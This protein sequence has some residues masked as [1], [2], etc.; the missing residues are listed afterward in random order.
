MKQS[1]FFNKVLGCQH[2]FFAS[3]CAVLIL[4]GCTRKCRSGTVLEK[5]VCRSSSAALAESDTQGEA[6][7][8]GASRATGLSDG[9]ADESGETERRLSN[10]QAAAGGASE[11]NE[12]SFATA[13]VGGANQ[14]PNTAGTFAGAASSGNGGNDAAR[15]ECSAGEKACVGQSLRHCGADGLWMMEMPCPFVCADGACVGECEPGSRQCSESTVQECDELGNWM[16]S[17]VCP[18]VCLDGACA[19]SCSPGS[20][21]CSGS[22]P[23]TC[24]ASGSWDNGTGCEFLCTNGECT[25]ECRPNDARCEGNRVQTC[26]AQGEWQAGSSCPFVCIDGSCTGQCRPDDV[27]C[28]GSQAERCSSEGRWEVDQ[29]CPYLCSDGRCTGSCKPGDTRCG[30]SSRLQVC[31]ANGSWNT[32]MVST[33]CGAECMPGQPPICDDHVPITCDSQGRLVRGRIQENTCGAQCT[34]GKSYDC[35][36]TRKP[37]CNDQ[38]EFEYTVTRDQCGAEC[39]PGEVGCEGPG[40]RCW[41]ANC[42]QIGE[43]GSPTGVFTCADDGTAQLATYCQ[44]KFCGDGTNLD[45]QC[46]GAARV[47]GTPDNHCSAYG[48]C[49]P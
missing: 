29:N 37:V 26:S 45:T 48:T 44:P 8:D 35:M 25:G 27:R 13:G 17:V 38:G 14:E 36:G 3:V 18:N 19:G 28:S 10:T 1:E 41:G 9:G 12:S 16:D 21:Q 5:G 7:V 42:R 23:Q 30:T 46:N 15:T 34:P 47:S 32:G 20:A 39:T 43:M 31:S 11:G 6:G 33:E 4:S 24:N 2:L 40:G 22:T 49:P